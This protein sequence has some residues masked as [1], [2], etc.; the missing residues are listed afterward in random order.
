MDHQTIFSVILTYFM[1]L[2]VTIIVAK[3]ILFAK[4]FN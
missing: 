2:L 4:F 1:N 3:D